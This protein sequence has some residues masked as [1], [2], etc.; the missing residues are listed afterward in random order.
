[1]NLTDKYSATLK[2][3]H[4]FLAAGY[5]PAGAASLAREGYTVAEIERAAAKALAAQDARGGREFDERAHYL[6]EC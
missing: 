2:A 3:Y 1:M 4:D 5:C 6:T